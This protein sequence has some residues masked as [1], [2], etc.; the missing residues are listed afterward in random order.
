MPLYEFNCQECNEK[1]EELVSSSEAAIKCPKCGSDKT[2]KLFSTFASNALKAAS[3]CGDCKP[4]PGF[5]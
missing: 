3:A 1:F 5:S 4:S 2:L